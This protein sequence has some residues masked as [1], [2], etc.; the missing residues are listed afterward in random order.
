MLEPTDPFLDYELPLGERIADKVIGKMYE[1]GGFIYENRVEILKAGAVAL[2]VA[3]TCVS[4][5]YGATAA[6]VLYESL[7]N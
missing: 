3:A 7:V 4:G 1:I 5:A 2:T 6:G